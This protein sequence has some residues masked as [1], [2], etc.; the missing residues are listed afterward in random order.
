MGSFCGERPAGFDGVSGG[1]K[2]PASRRFEIRSSSASVF[3]KFQPKPLLPS[4][5]YDNWWGSKP[6]HAKR[7]PG[8]LVS[9]KPPLE[10]NFPPPST[11]GPGICSSF[12]EWAQFGNGNLSL[13]PPSPRFGIGPLPLLFPFR[14]PP[15]CLTGLQ[16]PVP[17]ASADILLL[18]A[19]GTCE[20]SR[21]TS[22]ND[23]SNVG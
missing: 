23:G 15:S 8:F 17:T 10:M 20:S 5:N 3:F 1:M 14:E 12:A 7:V 4:S 21:P 2:L 16:P 19:S 6:N 11:D 22:P 18:A 9:F 13:S